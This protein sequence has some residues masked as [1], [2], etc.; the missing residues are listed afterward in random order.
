MSKEQR[1]VVRD[2]DDWVVKKPGA[3]RARS[4]DDT[5]READRRAAEILQNLGGGERI[6]HGTDGRIAART[7]SRRRAIRT[8]R[9]TRST[10]GRKAGAAPIG[11][12]MS[13]RSHFRR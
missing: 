3:D 5:Q 8:R 12:R 2:G 6:S 10:S 7:R 9:R 4:R 13:D 11:A 1:H